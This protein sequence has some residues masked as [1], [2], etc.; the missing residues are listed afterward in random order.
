ME[1]GERE[2]ETLR[3][4]IEEETGITKFRMLPRFRR[5]MQYDFQYQG[6]R[7]RREVIYF[8]IRTTQRVRVSDE[9]SQYKWL[10]FTQAKKYLKHENQ[11]KLLEEVER[12]MKSSQTRR[13]NERASERTN[14]RGNQR[15]NTQSGASTNRGAQS[16]SSR[17]RST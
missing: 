14:E 15:G 12:R 16:R 6:K 7:I 1:R 10:T 8:L 17:R 3:R 13:Q 2:L 5:T 9:H 11:V 4:E